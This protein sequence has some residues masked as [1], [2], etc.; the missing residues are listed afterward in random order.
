MLGII[1]IGVGVTMEGLA[2]VN[3][4]WLAVLGA[5]ITGFMSSMANGPL[6][7]VLQSVVRA[8]MQGR[9]MGLVNSAASAMSPLG[10]LIAGP[11][12]DA[13][14][15]RTWFWIAGVV[16]LLMGILGFF[17]PAVMNLENN[18]EDQSSDQKEKVTLPPVSG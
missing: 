14:G 6:G 2:P 4:F 17:I 5:I 9:V 11:V 3:L 16:T 13:I 10:L 15:I 12:S 1:G 18:R 8:D 7:A